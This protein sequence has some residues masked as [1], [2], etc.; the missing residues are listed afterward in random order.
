MFKYPSLTD[1]YSNIKFNDEITKKEMQRIYYVLSYMWESNF[2]SIYHNKK[3]VF[4]CF[5]DKQMKDI[6][7]S[8]NDP[9]F[10]RP[11]IPISIHAEVAG[12]NKIHAIFQ[13]TKRRKKYFLFVF[14][15]S[16]FGLMSNGK[17]CYHCLHFLLSPIVQTFLN[18]YDIYYTES[19]GCIKKLDLNNP[20]PVISSGYKNNINHIRNR[21]MKHH[22]KIS[23]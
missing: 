15:L 1:I 21:K 13:Q 22:K 5:F 2:L 7:I 8:R 6:I 17:P 14:G 18:L 3:N 19:Y 12:I 23:N 9:R 16:S 11:D 10:I 20:E 4:A